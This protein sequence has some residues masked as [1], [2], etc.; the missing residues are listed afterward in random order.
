LHFTEWFAASNDLD[1][2]MLKIW[3]RKNSVNV[4][5]V[6]WF[7]EEIALEYQRIDAGGDFGIVKT[8]EYR[9]L[10]PNALVPTIEDE[11]FVLWESNAIVRYLAA[12]H[13]ARDLWPD[14]LRA[15]AE[16]DQWMDWSSTTFW[17][18]IRPLFI[19][20]IRTPA[21]QRDP[22]SLDDHRLKSAEAL[23]IVDRHLESRPFLAGSTFTVSDIALG[24]GIWRWMAMP[25]ERPP[26]PNLQRWF[27][28][29]AQRPAYKKIVMLPLS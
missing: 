20:L 24:C 22:R 17:P 12:K 13:A 14:D 9:R 28:A 5:K 23:A 27:D 3:G 29:L 15:R 26:M 4:Q 8:P 16:A 10:N 2:D 1:L 11:G 6:L 25:I 19:G 7:C 18:A 21:D